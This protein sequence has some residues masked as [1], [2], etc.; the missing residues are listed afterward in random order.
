MK[1]IL[2]VLICQF[3]FNG[4]FAAD[5]SKKSP[6]PSF[7]HSE[8]HVHY[9]STKAVKVTSSHRRQLKN[10]IPSSCRKKRRTG[11]V[12]RFLKIQ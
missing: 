4:T 3:F 11:E 10:K 6:C 12:Q 7:H 1:T 5:R 2:F 8:V 9:R